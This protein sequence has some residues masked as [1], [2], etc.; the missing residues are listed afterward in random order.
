VLVA[1]R[2]KVGDNL[3][4]GKLSALYK[5][6]AN[7]S[8]YAMV[9]S[10]KQPPGGNFTVSGNVNS[11]Q[12][13]IYD[14]QES[15]TTEFGGKLDLLK[16]KLSLS[17]ALFRTDVKNEVEQD[18]V[19][20]QYY[21][22][23]EKRV[24]GIELGAT[25]ELAPHWLVSAGYVYMDTS[26]ERGRNVTASGENSLTYTPKQ[27]F[28]AWTSYDLPW[29]LRVGGGARFSDKLKRG[30]DGAIGTPAYTDSYWV[31]DA[32]L[33][34][35]VTKNI[36]LRLNVYNLTDEKY[37]VAI[38][39]SGYRYTPGVARSASLTANIGF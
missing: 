10:S 24:Q 36:D 27:S 39:K 3:V 30:T 18:P 32:M 12:N 34:Y 28:T 16:S 22:T 20:L 11:A 26:V 14:P 2:F 5:P 9:A 19:N 21:Q 7:S 25:G 33:G 37:V 6:T 4:N 38:N 17:G 1:N 29:G 35:R 13:P 31:V 23:G 8:V 15:T